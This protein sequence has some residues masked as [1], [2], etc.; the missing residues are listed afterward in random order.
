[1][2]QERSTQVSVLIT[3][4]RNPSHYI[5]RVTK[6]V[7]FSIPKSKRIT[8]GSLNKK[9]LFNYCKNLNIR[10]LLILEGSKK[11]GVIAV[12]AYSIEDEINS[13]NAEII[14]NN[15]TSITKQ[16]KNTR[17]MIEKICLGFS[18]EIS[19]IIKNKVTD[20]FSPIIMEDKVLRR[21]KLLIINFT[22]KN[23]KVLLGF[24]YQQ[25]SKT[26]RLLYEIKISFKCVNDE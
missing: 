5:R 6:I 1:M 4:S 26:S 18:K 10:R 21:N 24:A 9:Q 15:I 20:F 25:I 3:T 11:E 12:K 14:L 17:I 16:D 7:T 2:D 19:R 13:F 23:P 22:Q 8:R